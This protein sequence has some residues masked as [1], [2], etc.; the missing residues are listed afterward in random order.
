M[1]KTLFT[2]LLLGTVSFAYAQ[3]LEFDAGYGTNGYTTGAV[4][5]NYNNFNSIR[6][7]NDQTTIVLG[8][9]MVNDA[10]KGFI[11]KY[12]TSG[13]PDNTF[14]TNGITRFNDGNDIDHYFMA[15]E[16]QSDGKILVG[17][18]NE[19]VNTEDKTYYVKR[20]L[21]N[22]AIDSTFGTFGYAQI[23]HATNSLAGTHVS[24][25]SIQ[26]DGKILVC[27]EGESAITRLKTD[28][29]VDSTFG[30]NGIVDIDIATT[31]GLY[32][33]QVQA[34]AD[35]KIIIGAYVS[36]STPSSSTN[37]IWIYRLNNDGT[38]DNTFATSGKH[39]FSLNDKAVGIYNLKIQSDNKIVAGGF[40]Y[41]DGNDTTSLLLVRLN[42]NGTLDN[43][44]GAQGYVIYPIAS[45]DAEP[46]VLHLAGNTRLAYTYVDYAD[47]TTGIVMFQADGSPDATFNGSTELKKIGNIEQGV[48]APNLAF[49]DDGK[50]VLAGAV[51]LDNQWS[52]AQSFIG[53]L[54]PKA[55]SVKKLGNDVARIYPNPAQ[56]HL[57]I[58]LKNARQA[59]VAILDITGKVVLNSAIQD[60]QNIDVSNIPAG[61]YMI[62]ITTAQGTAQQKIQIVR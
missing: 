44:F 7:N 34:L 23:F 33:N 16:L 25:I 60:R 45:T 28:G 9:D 31:N 13:Q 18:Y 40:V 5:G 55:A 46:A 10:S 53:R 58:D 2:F 14:G 3:G 19:D 48:F 11:A 32:Y 39:I 35:G 54:Q 20:F 24:N 59:N 43:T 6:I 36:Y 42:T 52:T 41:E 17:G 21:T 30:T 57:T 49:Q 27:G 4:S 62:M 61:S 51:A 50:I 26:N 37:E 12:T 56:S 8:Q 15:L 1:K 29:T 38:L 22:G 47:N